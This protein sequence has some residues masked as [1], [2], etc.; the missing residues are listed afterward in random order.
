VA[1]VAA[2]P[3]GAESV[4]VTD[5]AEE[6]TVGEVEKVTPEVGELMVKVSVPA[7]TTPAP[8]S[9]NWVVPPVW[10][11]W[12][13]LM[14]VDVA[15]CVTPAPTVPGEASEVAE[16]FGTLACVTVV[17]P[18]VM[19]GVLA[20]PLKVSWP[21]TG[22]VLLGP[23]LLVPSVPVSTPPT[24]M[25]PAGPGSVPTLTNPQVDVTLTRNDETPAALLAATRPAAD[26]VDDA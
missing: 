2:S 5:P 19:V 22:T 13:G 10:F 15:V 23:V 14:F 6:V 24:M 16:Q 11:C 18:A 8:V 1:C 21:E 20:R 7:A 9:T 4:V 26:V 12:P 17:T 25:S 3:V